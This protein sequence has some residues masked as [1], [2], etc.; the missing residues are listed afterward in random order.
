MIVIEDSKGAHPDSNGQSTTGP[1]SQAPPPT[2]E[3]SVDHVVLDFSNAQRSLPGGEES[4]PEFTPYN[5][6]FFVSKQGWIISHDPHLNED[7]TR[8]FCCSL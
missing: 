6:D 4:P 7:G 2:F 1:S 8:F 3:E 5:A